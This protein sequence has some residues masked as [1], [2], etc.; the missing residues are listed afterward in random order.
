M[1]RIWPALTLAFPILDSTGGVAATLQDLVSAELDGLDVAAIAEQPEERWQVFFGDQA[2]RAAAAAALSAA[3]GTTGLVVTALDVPD[4]D[5]ARRSQAA[6]GAVRAGDI[7]VTPPWD[8]AASAA[9][10]TRTIVIEPAMGFGSGHHATTRL[11]LVALQRLDLHGRRVL[12]IGTGSGVLAL[13]AARLGAASV[14]AIDV[15]ADALDNAR[16]NATL[17]GDPAS[18]E[19]RMMDFRREAPAPADVVVANLT[20]GMLAASAAEVVGSVAAG[21]ALILSGMTREERGHVLAAFAG[22]CTVEWTAEEDE[23]CCVLLRTD[24]ESRI[25]GR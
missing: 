23:W 12:D 4:G 7:V 17:N 25:A 15:D 5:W 8:P 11:C 16:L 9:G 14:L 6:L 19:F 22:S 20:G 21:G 18:V 1:R 24:R 3:F 2:R 13:A 10:D